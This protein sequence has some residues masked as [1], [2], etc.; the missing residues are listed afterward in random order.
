M[1]ELEVALG[2]AIAAHHMASIARRRNQDEQQFTLENT[3]ANTCANINAVMLKDAEEA[4]ELVS[5][6]LS[7]ALERYKRMNAEVL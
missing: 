3:R 2:A 6:K 7:D 1:N 4:M 5:R